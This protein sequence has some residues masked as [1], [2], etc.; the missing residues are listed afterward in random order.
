MLRLCASI[1]Q[2]GIIVCAITFGPAPNAA[3]RET[4]TR[5][6]SDPAIELR[7]SGQKYFHAPTGAALRAAFENIAGQVQELR[8]VQ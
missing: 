6:A 5:C 1:K 4:Y 7:I 3:T 2:A 8:L